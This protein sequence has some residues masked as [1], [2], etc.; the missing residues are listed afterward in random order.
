MINILDDQRFNGS[1]RTS[2]SL[3]TILAEEFISMVKNN[4][5]LE[6]DV[7]SG[8]K[9]TRFCVSYNFVFSIEEV[10]N[11]L[12]LLNNIFSDGKLFKNLWNCMYLSI[13]LTIFNSKLFQHM[14]GSMQSIRLQT[15]IVLNV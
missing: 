10:K 14:I 7:G 4:T 12:R 5:K 9:F 6:T 8:G 2:E 15:V 13:F 3:Y 11:N 1:N